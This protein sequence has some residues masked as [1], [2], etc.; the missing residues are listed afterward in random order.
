[1]PAGGVE[2]GDAVE[3]REDEVDPGEEERQDE[4]PEDEKALE[5]GVNFERRDLQAGEFGAE[6]RAEAEAQH[7]DRDH[8]RGRVDAVAEKE[9]ELARPGDLKDEGRGSRKEEYRADNGDGESRS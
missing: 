9:F 6:A 5:A 4:G 2:A 1:M 8:R 3:E 7:V